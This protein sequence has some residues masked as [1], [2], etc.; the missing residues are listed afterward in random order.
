[1]KTSQGASHLAQIRQLKRI[2]GQIRGIL[3]MIEDE[4]YCID[5]LTQIKAAKS[6]LTTIER[7]I[8]DQHMNHC[9]HTA[10]QSKNPQHANK[11]LDEIQQLLKSSRS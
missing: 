6:S 4:R 11:M 9:I 1:M 8:I 5:I 7:N 2:E 3:K 10:I